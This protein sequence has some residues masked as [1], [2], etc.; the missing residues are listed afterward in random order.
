MVDSLLTAISAVDSN[1]PS[2]RMT[3]RCSAPNIPSRDFRDVTA[4]LRVAF[5]SD[6]IVYLLDGIINTEGVAIVERER[7]R[8]AFEWSVTFNFET[9]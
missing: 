5:E 3:S 7:E 2:S 9:V 8:E 1:H 4:A 6:N